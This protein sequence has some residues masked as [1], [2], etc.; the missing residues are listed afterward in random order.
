VQAN[1]LLVANN[2]TVGRDL[3]AS[4]PFLIQFGYGG[5]P[6]GPVKVG[7]DL[8][9]SGSDAPN[10]FYIDVCDTTV[11]RDLR[12]TDSVT[13]QEIMVG[14]TGEFCA[15]SPS[16]PDTIGRDAI[17][18]GNTVGTSPFNR[19]VDVGNN[20]VGRDLTVSGNT[21]PGFIDVS[22]NTV[23]RDANCSA[24]TPSPSKDG[25]DDGPNSA[26]RHNTCG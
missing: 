17:I 26:G 16:P 11:G 22:D 10:G 24:N 7:R 9:I 18:T 20:S 8:K 6:S 4:K 21:A 19:F 3:T 13:Q 1:A 23:S 15:G 25:P 14:D 12:I 2:T 5:S